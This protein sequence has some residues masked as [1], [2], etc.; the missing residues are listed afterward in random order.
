MLLFGYPY[1]QPLRIFYVD[2]YWDRLGEMRHC[3]L[4]HTDYGRPGIKG[5]T[6][7]INLFTCIGNIW[8]VTWQYGFYGPAW[9][10]DLVTAQDEAG[11][12][13]S[14]SDPFEAWF[15]VRYYRLVLFLPQPHV[16]FSWRMFHILP[17]DTGSSA[18]WVAQRVPD[19]HITAVA[20]QVHSI[21]SDWVTTEVYMTLFLC[22][23]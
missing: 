11:E 23:V 3:S 18:I 7:S 10:E 4:C 17:D 16:F 15:V 6:I 2:S 22:F 1:T 9:D 8:L 19:D 20:N 5:W 21:M 13:L 14:I 12:A